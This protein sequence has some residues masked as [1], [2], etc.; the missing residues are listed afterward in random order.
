M[1]ENNEEPNKGINPDVQD[2]FVAIDNA[3][4]S[5]YFNEAK[6]S[7]K[8]K[9]QLNIIKKI[10]DDEKSKMSIALDQHD[11][12]KGEKNIDDII[13]PVTQSIIEEIKTILIGEIEPEKVQQIIDSISSITIENA[14]KVIEK[15][16]NSDRNNDKEA[17]DNLENKANP[18]GQPVIDVEE[19]NKEQEEPKT[20]SN[21]DNPL[22]DRDTIE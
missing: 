2:I 1:N 21:K 3:V 13:H 14:H 9:E 4:D 6:D 10:I 15:N 11:R 22:G 16:D 18:L 20:D 7:Q 17:S 19:T 12:G 8:F 5:I